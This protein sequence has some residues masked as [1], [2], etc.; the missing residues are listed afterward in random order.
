MYRGPLFK[1]DAVNFYTPGPSPVGL[2][3]SHNSL[4]HL[5]LLI[6]RLPVDVPAD[7]R[8]VVVGPQHRWSDRYSRPPLRNCSSGN[9]KL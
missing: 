6:E 7:R 1:D 2:V 4:I 5:H 3:D 9:V 8:T